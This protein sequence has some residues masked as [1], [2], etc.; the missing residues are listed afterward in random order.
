MSG[1]NK[2]EAD[3]FLE[4]CFEDLKEQEQFL[5]KHGWVKKAGDYT[6]WI[7]PKGEE[8]SHDMGLFGTHTR[9]FPKAKH[10]IVLS[11]GFIQFEVQIFNDEDEPKNKKGTEEPYDWFFPCIKD[12]KLYFYEEAVSIAC[13]G[14]ESI[15]D[16]DR[17]LALKKLLEKDLTNI[18]HGD[19]IKV[20]EFYNF[21]T[22]EYR[23]EHRSKNES[24]N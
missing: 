10:D 24:I 11:S 22:K 8:Y 18:Q 13:Y 7:S 4:K 16:L 9:A 2:E 21:D 15:Y 17:W 1:L 6:T 19:I 23:F 12:G 14:V 5:L 3:K 20:V